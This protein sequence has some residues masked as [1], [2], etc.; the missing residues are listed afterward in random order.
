M[1]FHT[2]AAVG[3]TALLAA[4][5]VAM[6]AQA[7]ERLRPIGSVVYE[8]EPATAIKGVYN[9]RNE[10]RR[11]RGMRILAEE[12]SADVRA[13]KVIYTD[14]EVENVRVRQVLREGERTAL[15][16]LEEPRPIRSVEVSS[17]PKGA[18]T[19]VLLAD[20]RRAEPPA[21]PQWVELACK[22]VSIIGERDVVPLGSDQ[23]YR[24][25]RL[26]SAN[27]DIE[28]AEMTVRYANGGRDNYQIRQLIPAGG[29]I[30]P[31]DLRGERRR[32]SQLD[33][34]YRA[35]T[36]GPFKT[37]LCVDGLQAGSREDDVTEDE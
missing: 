3:M 27:Y 31:I 21:P 26:R 22:N 32:I 13:L 37:K 29:R 4:G 30:G 7:Q 1:R 11:I 18:V 10:D 34:V 9:I 35:R 24:A 23:R 6:P 5:V 36:I 16:Q 28:M 8:P 19:L 15:F 12:G 14:G 2:L 20:S 25:L 33:F 17:I